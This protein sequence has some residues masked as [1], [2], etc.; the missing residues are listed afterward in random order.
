[1]IHDYSCSLDIQT[2]NTVSFNLSSV[3]A[4]GQ[5]IEITFNGTY[6]NSTG[7]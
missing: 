3:G 4:V 6:T 7:S 1:M 2:I 5:Y